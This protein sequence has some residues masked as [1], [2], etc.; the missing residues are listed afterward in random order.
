MGTTR[1]KT[2]GQERPRKSE[3]AKRKRQNTQKKRLAVAGFTEA[4]MKSM[5]GAQLR[6]SLRQVARTLKPTV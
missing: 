5:N 6:A 4:A 3:A 2:T 1:L